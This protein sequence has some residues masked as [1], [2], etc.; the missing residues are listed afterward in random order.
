M[1]A[2]RWSWLA[3]GVGAYLAFALASFPAGTAYRWFVPDTVTLA[4]IQ[5]TLWS[6]RAGAASVGGLTVQ[7]LR[8]R[9]RPWPLFVGR[10]SADVEARLPDGF[11]SARVSASP[12]TVL[13]T[14]VRASTSI[15]ALRDVLPV[16]GVRGQASA[17]FS[18]LRLENG[19]PTTAVGE[20]RLGQLEAAPFIPNGQQLVLLGDYL[21]EFQ[22]SA[23]PEGGI[24]ATFK[25]S[26]ASG[27]LEVAGTL[28][29]DARRAYTLDAMI[30][31]R[32]GA[33]PDLVQGLTYMSADPDAAGRR[34]LTLTGSL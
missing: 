25:D 17:T 6:G 22:P 11:V 13:L 12:A 34:R 31:P 18:E 26:N 5:G 21:V 29:L 8:W 32:A 30:L 33:N 2:N 24:A 28:V 15:P 1:A 27:P 14:D 9:V 16:S 19:W 23:T 20:L 10:L 7:N 3:L 4:G